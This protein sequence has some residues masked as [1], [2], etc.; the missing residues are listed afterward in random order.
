MPKSELE[1][2]GRDLLVA[3]RFYVLVSVKARQ[4]TPFFSLESFLEHTPSCQQFGPMDHHSC[5]HPP[6]NFALLP[7]VDPDAAM[8]G[9]NH[10]RPWLIAQIE[11]IFEQQVDT[12]LASDRNLS[13]SLKS[14][15]R[16]LRQP[17]SLCSSPGNTVS[18]DSRTFRFPGRSEQEAWRYSQLSFPT[19]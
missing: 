14:R 1:L 8:S 4:S 7:D 12:V 6:P 13:I 3:W 16:R 9:E 17:L 10:D 19:F 2:K 15:T 18:T 5:E 11:Q